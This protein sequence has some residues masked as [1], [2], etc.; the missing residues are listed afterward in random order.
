MWCIGLAATGKERLARSPVVVADIGR[1]VRTP[2]L[3]DR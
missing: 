3:A 1:L 2:I